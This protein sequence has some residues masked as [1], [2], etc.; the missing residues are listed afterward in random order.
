MS[1]VWA[2][3]LVILRGVTGSAEGSTHQLCVELG[4]PGLA[5]IVENE[6]RVNHLDW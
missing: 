3:S 5:I 4:Q 6:N 2:V 1:W